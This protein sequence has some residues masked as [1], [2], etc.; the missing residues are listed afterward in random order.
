MDNEIAHNRLASPPAGK[1]E[2]F[3]REV[4]KGDPAALKEFWQRFGPRIIAYSA[5]RLGGDEDL[6]EE[7][8]VQ[9]LAAAVRSIGNFDGRRASLM[10]WVYGVARRTIG[11]ELRRQR[12]RGAIPKTAQVPLDNVLEQTGN[13]KTDS[14]AVSRLEAQRQVRALAITLSPAEMEVLVLHFV[15]EF[16]VKEIAG[17]M[18]RSWRAIDSLLSRARQK[19]RERLERDGH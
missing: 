16:S 8:M 3:L 18:G 14:D 2:G 1:E 4:G 9:T 17:I 15:E 19:A 13:E 12:K 11:L 5:S 10:A 6:A 7:V